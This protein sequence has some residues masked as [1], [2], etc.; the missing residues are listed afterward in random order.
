MELLVLVDYK[1]CRILH[2][3]RQLPHDLHE[4]VWVPGPLKQRLAE[5]GVPENGDTG[6]IDVR[7]ETQFFLFSNRTDIREVGILVA[8]R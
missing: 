6:L 4:W 5:Y 3:L 8:F 7:W 1:W 2:R